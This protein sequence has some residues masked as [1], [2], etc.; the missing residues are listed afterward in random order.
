MDWFKFDYLDFSVFLKY[1]FIIVLNV[2]DVLMCVVI[3][4][5]VRIMIGYFINNNKKIRN[6]MMWIDR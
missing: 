3:N 2:I 1:D 5:G 4:F 6:S